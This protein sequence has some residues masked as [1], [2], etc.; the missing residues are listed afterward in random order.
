MKTVTKLDSSIERQRL[1]KE[2]L[3]SNAMKKMAI[4]IAKEKMG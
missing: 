2:Q 1:T 4:N 3:A